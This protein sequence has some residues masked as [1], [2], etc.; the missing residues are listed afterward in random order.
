M[1]HYWLGRA[2]RLVTISAL[3]ATAA[4]AA[5]LG[6]RAQQAPPTF[7][8][9]VDLIAVDAQVVDRA[10][11]PISTLDRDNFEVTIDGRKRRV[12]SASL[13]QAAPASVIGSLAAA[14]AAPAAPAAGRTFILAI[15]AG[16]FTPG[17]TLSVLTAAKEFVRRLPPDDQVGLFTLPP[18]GAN[19]L[20]SSNHGAVRVALD[21]IIGER[22]SLPG[23]YHLSM[24][25]IIDISTESAG[26]SAPTLAAL[27]S[28]AGRGATSGIVG[29]QNALQRVQ[30]R[31]CRNAADMACQEAILAEAASMAQHF[32]ERVLQSLS[33]LN[34]LLALLREFP[35][36]KTVVVLSAGMAV[37]DRPGGR[38]DVG[39]EARML[40]EEAAHANATIYALHLDLGMKEM[41]GA[42]AR[43][44]PGATELSRE[45]SMSE[46]MLDQFSG[47]SGGALLSVL[48]GDGEIALDRVLRETSAFYLLGVEPANIDRDN[49]AHKLNVKVNRPGT[50]VRSRQWVV[51]RKPGRST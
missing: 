9:T 48:V 12:V 6:A 3:A 18:R 31:E 33:G 11:N 29:D 42:Q 20:P 10:G 26:L 49:R 1:H 30:Q 15:D 17:E 5:G 22:Q 32:D 47:A 23:Q 21:H 40:G 46:R 43:R 19:V 34:S 14:H 24:S 41:Y 36:R 7:R 25:E 4:V 27:T 50:T 13:V 8:A 51:L 39:S 38:L 37:S 28:G 45:Q 44:A 2:G 35:G 16:S